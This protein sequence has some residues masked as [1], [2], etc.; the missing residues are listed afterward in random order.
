[1]LPIELE[2]SKAPSDP[3]VS[4]KEVSRKVWW[5][6]RRWLELTRLPISLYTYARPLP[7]TSLVCTFSAQVIR[8][9]NADRPLSFLLNSPNQP[10]LTQPSHQ[11]YPPGVAQPVVGDTPFSMSLKSSVLVQRHATFQSLPIRSSF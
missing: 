7:C 10:H 3:T 2:E 8:P 11:E 4:A 1:M 5:R 9:A 6:F